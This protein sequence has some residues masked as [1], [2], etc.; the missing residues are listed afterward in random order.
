MFDMRK[1]KKISITINRELLEKFEQLTTNKVAS[2]RD[3]IEWFSIH[4]AQPFLIGYAR[5]AG[6]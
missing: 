5:Q 3:L 6:Y 2:M 1:K 4:S